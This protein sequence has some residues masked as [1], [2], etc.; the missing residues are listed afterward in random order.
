M[1]KNT[2]NNLKKDLLDLYCKTSNKEIE[3]EFLKIAQAS[4]E[5]M[6]NWL[7]TM[8]LEKMGLQDINVGRAIEYA[9]KIK[10]KSGGHVTMA[11][12]VNILN[13]GESQP[14]IKYLPYFKSFANIYNKGNAEINSIINHIMDLVG[15]TK[16]MES[17]DAN[18]PE[19]ESDLERIAVAYNERNNADFIDS[20]TDFG[21]KVV[22]KKKESKAER[23]RNIW[24]Y[25]CNEFES[26]ISTAALNSGNK[27]LA[28]K[29]KDGVI[30]NPYAILEMF[31]VDKYE[32]NVF[33]QEAQKNILPYIKKNINLGHEVI[34]QTILLW[35]LKKAK[36]I[37]ELDYTKMFLNIVNHTSQYKEDLKKELI[38]PE[39]EPYKITNNNFIFCISIVLYLL[40]KALTGI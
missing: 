9:L 23:L 11:N 20:Y 24:Y 34:Y 39:I 25:L 31:N 2:L 15:L 14:F 8:N 7:Y 21:E 5:K 27:E 6:E 37:S 4:D 33:I 18:E 22:K 12:L 10:K 38:R 35:A 32:M 29:L 1:Q 19:V 26:D 28:V 30:N 16:M 13:G 3:K 17:E 40:Q 36:S